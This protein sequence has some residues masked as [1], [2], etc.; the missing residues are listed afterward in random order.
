MLYPIELRALKQIL[1]DES[2]GLTPQL[3][4]AALLAMLHI[5]GIWFSLGGA[6]QNFP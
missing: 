3:P 1:H 2:N 4:V 6:R 5:S